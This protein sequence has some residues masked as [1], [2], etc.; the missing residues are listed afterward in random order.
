MTKQSATGSIHIEK[1]PLLPDF[2]LLGTDALLNG[3]AVV[4]NLRSTLEAEAKTRGW[5]YF[6][7]A[8][9]IGAGAFGFDPQQTERAA[10]SRLATTVKSQKCNSFQIVCIVNSRFLGV[11][12]VTVTAH[13]RN[14]QRGAVCFGV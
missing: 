11:S 12:R 3:W 8:G 1:G 6:F 5:N 13:A 10:L 14:L 7:M 2:L 4:K 9:K